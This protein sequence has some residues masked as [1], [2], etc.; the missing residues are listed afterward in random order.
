MLR[1]VGEEAEEMFSE[2]I[3][4]RRKNGLILGNKIEEFQLAF[5]TLT[6]VDLF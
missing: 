2:N 5:A 4:K 1:S 3:R 6:S